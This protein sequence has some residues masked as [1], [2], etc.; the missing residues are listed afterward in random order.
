MVTRTVSNSAS[1]NTPIVRLKIRV[2][3]ADG[4]SRFLNPGYSGNGKLRPLYAIV[5]GHQEHH[6]EGVY[7]MEYLRR[8]VRVYGT[9]GSDSL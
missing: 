8:G 6:P 1:P 2:K 3:L 4:S 7:A 9:I 5:N